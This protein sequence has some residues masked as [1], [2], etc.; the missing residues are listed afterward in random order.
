MIYDSEP[1]RNLL[2]TSAQDLTKRAATKRVTER[3]SIFTERTVFFAAYAMRKLDD[4]KKLSTSWRGTTVSCMRYPPTDT[5]WGWL[6]RDHLDQHYA[7]EK[8]QIDNMGARAFCDLVVHSLIFN[9]YINDNKTIG[10]FFI[11]SDNTKTRGIWQFELDT[12]VRLMRRTAEDWPSEAYFIRNP[13]TGEMEVWAG[14]SE[15]PAAWKEKAKK[16]AQ[17]RAS[18]ARPKVG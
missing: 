13:T 3:R 11:T 15:P 14:N 18:L 12:I 16:F 10:G 17:Q 2:L 9:E 4:S 1:W 7:L 5:Q 6:E 8:S